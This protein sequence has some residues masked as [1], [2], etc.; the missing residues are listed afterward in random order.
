MVKKIT[1]KKLRFGTAYFVSEAKARQYYDAYN[2]HLENV[3][4]EGRCHL[5]E[6][7]HDSNKQ[8]IDIDSDGRYW[9]EDI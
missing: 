7:P 4:A 5:G 2:E 9:I 1:I 3:L 8:R 6:P